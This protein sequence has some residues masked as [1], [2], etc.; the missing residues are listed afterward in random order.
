MLRDYGSKTFQTFLHLFKDIA[1][2]FVATATPSPNR[3]KELSHYAAY[4]GIM[5]SGQI[6]T[7]FFQRDSSSAGNLTLHPHTEREFWL[8]LNTWACFIQKPSDLGYSDDGYEL[9]GA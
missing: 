6:L 9:P 4:L 5:D 3:F 7:R 1:F 8:W 2:R